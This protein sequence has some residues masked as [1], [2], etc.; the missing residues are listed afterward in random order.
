MSYNTFRWGV[1]AKKD[2]LFRGGL[3]KVD[4]LGQGGGRGSIRPDLGVD[5]LFGWPLGHFYENLHCLPVPESFQL[6]LRTFCTSLVW[7]YGYEY[8]LVKRLSSYHMIYKGLYGTYLKILMT[9]I[10]NAYF[11][12]TM[13]LIK[14]MTLINYS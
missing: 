7:R 9:L 6:Q 14:S 11:D 4:Q 2:V 3:G 5:V 1:L 8:W 12:T 13:T 10:K